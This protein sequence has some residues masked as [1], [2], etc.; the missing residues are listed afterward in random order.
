MY[1]AG[2]G[3]LATLLSETYFEA[4]RDFQALE[5]GCVSILQLAGIL[6]VNAHLPH[7]GRRGEADDCHGPLDFISAFV[8]ARRG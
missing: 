5:N 2:V 1:H 3:G 8:R 4:V 6:L 7:S